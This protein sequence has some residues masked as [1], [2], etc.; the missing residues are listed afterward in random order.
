M[1]TRSAAHEVQVAGVFHPIDN[2][3]HVWRTIQH[4]QNLA[5]HL[6]LLVDFLEHE[7]GVTAFLNSFHRL[8]DNFRFAL[9]QGSILDRMQFHPV[10]P[11]RNHLAILRSN[12]F[13]GER[14]NGGQ[15][16]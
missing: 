8:G 7:V 12:N 4:V 16:G 5:R 1:V 2:G 14:Q 11:Q 6:A 3:G 13:A 9:D 10:S 15:I